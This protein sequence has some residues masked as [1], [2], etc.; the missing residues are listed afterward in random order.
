MSGKRSSKRLEIVNPN[1][2]GIDI[3]K[4]RHYVAVD[5]ARTETPIR[6]FET[7]TDDLES[8]AVW[9]RESEVTVV[10]MEATGVYWIPVFE[11]L[12]RAGFEVLLVDP[13]ATKQVSGRKSDVLDCQWIWQ[14]TSYGLLRGA[15]RPSDSVCELR[16]YVRQRRHL[17]EEAGRSIQHIQKALTQ[18]NLQL[19]TVLS[20]IM[21]KTGQQILRAIDAGER[22]PAVLARFRDPRVKVDEMTI[23]RSLQGNWRAEHLLAMKLALQRY[24]LLQEQILVCEAEMH[25]A[26]DLLA[27]HEVDV[28]AKASKQLRTAGERA[29]RLHLHRTLGVDLMRIPT[30]GLEATLT[31][32]AE[33]GPDLAKFP[34]FKHFCSWL[35]LAP[36]TRISGDRRLGGRGPKRINRTGQAL[37]QA[38]TTARKNKSF[39]GAAH[40]GR[41]A[42]LG[43]QG[44]IKATA[45][46]LA[47]LIYAM[48]TRGEEY[49]ER[50][51]ETFEEERRHRQLKHLERRAREIGMVLLAAPVELED[52]TLVPT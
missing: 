45:H 35:N 43:K 3:G 41:I 20:D 31:I 52:T 24:D 6:S 14:L 49:V 18:M 44:A 23:V 32:A 27:I 1:C 25:R 15:F 51:M 47:R 33:L 39:I 12:D 21:G 2:A 5:P 7:F 42:R 16:S 37:R 13:R 4:T 34:S 29:L 48:M 40:R 9:L 8:L 30:I 50:G 17:K 10:A 11:L 38:A 22:D 46:Q 28:D 36:P 19:D 26:L